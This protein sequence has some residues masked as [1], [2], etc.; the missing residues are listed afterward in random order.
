MA[1]ASVVH[2]SLELCLGVWSETTVRHTLTPQVEANEETHC[3]VSQRA[4]A[5]LTELDEM[6]IRAERVWREKSTSLSLNSKYCENN[7]H[8]VSQVLRVKSLRSSTK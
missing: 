8:L 6:N 1:I 2:L 7:L 4:T 3:K 5:V